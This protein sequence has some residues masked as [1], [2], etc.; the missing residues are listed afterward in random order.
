MVRG[1]IA[2]SWVLLIALC[3]ASGGTA[4]CG[5]DP[6]HPEPADGRAQ[7]AGGGSAIGGNAGMTAG[8]SGGSQP[9]SAGTGAAGGGSPAAMGL[10][11][12]ATSGTTALPCDVAGVIERRCQSCHARTPLA[13]V[14]MA[15]VSWEDLH[16]A[17]VTRS[18]LT[19]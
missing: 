11:G 17:A 16:A 14:P 8:G 9:L 19:V 6:E 18:E 7:P 13:G 1:S 15:L 5:Q 10:A 3:C 2:S 4:A 12:R